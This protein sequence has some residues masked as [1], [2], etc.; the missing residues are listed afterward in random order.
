Y[1]LITAHSGCNNTPPN[2]MESLIVGMESGADFVE[3]DVR[4][5]KNGLPVLFHDEFIKTTNQGKVNICDYTLS[6]L[7]NFIKSDS[8]M[9]NQYSEIITF[10][11]AV[12]MAKEYGCFLNVDIKEDICIDPMAMIIKDA[13]MVDSVI[14]TGCKYKRAY[15]LKKRYP[16]LQVL[17]N[18]GRKILKG[19]GKSTSLIAD[20]V[21]RMAVDASCC[22]INIEFK[23]L[24]DELVYTALRRFLPISIWTLKESDN[25][26]EYL[27][28]GL[29]SIT[30]LAVDL[31]VEKR[32]KFT[33]KMALPGILPEN[34]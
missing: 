6:E 8:I 32:K 18:V 7:N 25:L 1:T 29:Y 34:I 27:K 15:S 10:S 22:G 5:E 14:I 4:S 11:R 2:S 26:D 16:Q 9:K 20:E 12:S 23:Y 19:N 28:M 24:T 3:V 21:C 30:T 17:L 13:D 31:L 33:E